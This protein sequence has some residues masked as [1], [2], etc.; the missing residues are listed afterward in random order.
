MGIVW[1]K[2]WESNKKS[3]SQI[4]ISPEPL[5]FSF[6]VIKSRQPEFANLFQK[7]EPFMLKQDKDELSDDSHFEDSVCGHIALCASSSH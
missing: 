6:H 7:P 4:Q 3:I 2:D 1:T 5:F